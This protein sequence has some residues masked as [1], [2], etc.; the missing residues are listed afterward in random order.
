MRSTM[1]EID[2]EWMGGALVWM[3]SP[4][5]RYLLATGML[6]KDQVDIANEG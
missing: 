4:R 6:I 3:E 2:L 1:C 5:R